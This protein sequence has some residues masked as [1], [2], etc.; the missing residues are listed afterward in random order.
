MGGC[1]KM[2]L[3]RFLRFLVSLRASYAGLER[4]EKQKNG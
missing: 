3:N 4:Q 2:D 1:S